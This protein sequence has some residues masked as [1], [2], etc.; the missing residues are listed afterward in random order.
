[1]FR[2]VFVYLSEC[3]IPPGCAR[4]KLSFIHSEVT[5]PALPAIL[6][7]AIGMS[8]IFLTLSAICSSAN[9]FVANLL[10]LRAAFLEQGIL[11][12]VLDPSLAR[13]LIEHPLL[14]RPGTQPRTLP[15]YIP[16]ESFALALLDLLRRRVGPTAARVERLRTE[17]DK[18]TSSAIRQTLSACLAN[19]DATK[20]LEDLRLAIALIQDDKVRSSISD[21][22]NVLEVSEIKRG[23]LTISDP[24]LQQVLFAILNDAETQ[25][26]RLDELKGRIENW[27]NDGMD[28]VSLLYK[29]YVTRLL[30]ILAVVLCVAFNADA[31]HILNSLWRD[32]TLRAAIVAQAQQVSSDQGSPGQAANPSVT[33]PIENAI[34]SLE[35]LNSFPVGWNC[36]EYN[37]IARAGW[38]SVD[39]AIATLPG[40]T[41]FCDQVGG[42]PIVGGGFNLQNLLLKILGLALMSVGVSLG[43]PFWFDALQKLVA[44][45]PD[46]K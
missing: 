7:V 23:I 5:V 10:K 42:K 26:Q 32:P 13:Q 14:S 3:P 11:N 18:I 27:F 22:F 9:E 24:R 1:M 39:S 16:S 6:E 45:R 29:R 41:G 38:T 17:V 34:R 30:R 43:A 21:F 8:L 12:L 40:E 37:D 44:L 20:A 2:A 46:K 36:S 19:P 15:A 4:I 33:L 28:R 25:V 31:L 35:Q